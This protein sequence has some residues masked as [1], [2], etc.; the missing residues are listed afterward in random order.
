M[1]KTMKLT[2]VNVGYGEAILLECPDPRFMGGTFVMLI[3]GGR[4]DA[5]EYADRTSGRIPLAEYVA[6]HGLDHIDLMVCTHTHE[7]HISGLLPV[8]QKLTPHR[9]WQ[10]LPESFY[11]ELPPLDTALGQNQ[12]QRMFL[13]ALNDYV[14]LCSL[15]AERGTVS[16]MCAGDT[17]ELCQG[18]TCRI[19]SPTAQRAAQLMQAHRELYAQRDTAAFLEKLSALDGKMNNYSLMLLL[20][21][22]GTRILLPG[23][24]NDSGYGDVSPDDL[25]AHIF[26]VGHHGQK[27]G[28]AEAQIVKI[29]P[30]AVVCCASSDR[31]FQ[32]AAPSLMT[33]L[34][35]NGAALWFSDCPAVEGV[36]IPPHHALTFTVGENGAFAAQYHE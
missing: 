35:K 11:R 32:S 5:E 3:D 9:L 28:V 29:R 25:P 7:D 31:R 27:D 8:A 10:T 16:A 21:Y 34:Q 15:V 26:K 17:V 33:M 23:D 30:K 2:F 19:L 14:S 4:G 12:S 22:R 6:L 20:N 36:D 13:R 18:L 1:E 24:T